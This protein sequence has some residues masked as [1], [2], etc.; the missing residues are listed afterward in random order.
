MP[1][2]ATIIR[3]CLDQA[4][5]ASSHL[6]STCIDD[7]IAGLME[8]EQKGLTSAERHDVSDACREL[9]KHRASWQERYPRDPRRRR[10]AWTP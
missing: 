4:V 7:A 3:K 10:C 8:A 6:I 5:Q 2:Q 1:D 9:L